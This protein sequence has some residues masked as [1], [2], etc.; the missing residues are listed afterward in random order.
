MIAG[1]VRGVEENEATGP[2]PDGM[3]CQQQP[4]PNQV[5]DQGRH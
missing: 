4:G 5:K 3:V 2:V 1:L